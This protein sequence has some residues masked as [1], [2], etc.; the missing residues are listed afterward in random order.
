MEISKLHRTWQI[1]TLKG[2]NQLFNAWFRN[3]LISLIVKDKYIKQY[4]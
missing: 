4:D 3:Y 1:H 2:E